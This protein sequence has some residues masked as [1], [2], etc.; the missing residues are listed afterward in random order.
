MVRAHQ[1]LAVDLHP[2]LEAKVRRQYLMGEWELAAFAAMKLIEVRVRRLAQESNSML[3]AK[4][5]TAA[6]SPSVPGPLFD[7][8]M[9]GGEAVARMNLFAGAIGLFKNP[10]SH[11]DVEFDDPAEAAEVILFADLLLRILD[12]IEKAAEERRYQL[13]VVEVGADLANEMFP[14]RNS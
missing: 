10:T 9:D 6:F 3:G 2:S 7:P 14:F 11:R 8:T 12:R 1:R 5:M 4:L 13:A